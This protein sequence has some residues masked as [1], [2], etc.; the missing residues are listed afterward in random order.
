MDTWLLKEKQ[1][2][3]SESS[4]DSPVPGRKP[5]IGKRLYVPG[6]AKLMPD[7]LAMNSY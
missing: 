1:Y 2:V 3:Q 4:V 7:F 5:D 6:E